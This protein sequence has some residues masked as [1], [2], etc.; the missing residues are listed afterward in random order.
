MP[1][2]FPLPSLGTKLKV[3]GN[4]VSYQWKPVSLISPLH[5]LCLCGCDHSI[6][7]EQLRG[8][9]ISC[10][11]QFQCVVVEKAQPSMRF[12]LSQWGVGSRLLSH[13][14]RKQKTPSGSVLLSIAS[15]TGDQ[16]LVRDISFK[17]R[18]YPNPDSSEGWISALFSAWWH[19]ICD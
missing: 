5:Q 9:K 11:S 13:R 2:I 3:A 15:T 17:T 18:M 14:N 7:R 10:G 4:L 16:E 8:R 19:R 6:W 12:L 1:G